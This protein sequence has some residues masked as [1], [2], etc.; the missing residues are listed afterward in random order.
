[1]AELTFYHQ[2]RTDGG[3]RTGI[4]NESGPL[5]HYFQ[6]GSEEFDP[7]LLWY[8]D[9]RCSGEELPREPR[10]ARDWF[11]KNSKFFVEHLKQVAANLGPGFDADYL[12]YQEEIEDA[13]DGARARIVISAARRLVARKIPSEL[14]D[15]A[16]R[17][18]QLLDRL[19]L[20]SP[21]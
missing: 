1:M 17:W 14:R 6:E 20:L 19:D 10:A 15:V 21:V 7:R 9:V 13:P 18:T 5:L 8:V 2:V 4:D 16:E 12:P 3:E 11:L